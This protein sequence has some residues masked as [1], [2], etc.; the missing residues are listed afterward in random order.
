[1]CVRA[2][3]TIFLKKYLSL[4]MFMIKN[5]LHVS[6]NWQDKLLRDDKLIPHSPKLINLSSEYKHW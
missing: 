1:M 4:F 2:Q 6:G 5:K 3:V